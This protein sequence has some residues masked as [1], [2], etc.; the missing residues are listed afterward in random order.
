MGLFGNKEEKAAQE[1]AGEAEVSRLAGLS[2]EGLAVEVMPAFGPG[3][4]R[5]KGREGTPPMQIVQWLV[6]DYPR[7]PSLRS[8]VDAVL[9]ALGLLERS[10]L[11]RRGTSGVGSG[12]QLYALT[13][14]G[15]E[16]LADGSVRQRLSA[17]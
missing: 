16:A 13:P 14:S 6:S 5:S 2:V 17:G 1:A 7:H 8:L 12:G 11:L 10:G 15:E 9:A 4:A 3:G